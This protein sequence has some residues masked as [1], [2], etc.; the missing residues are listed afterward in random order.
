MHTSST[1]PFLAL[2]LICFSQI[3]SANVDKLRLIARDDPSTTIVIGW[4]QVTGATPIVYYD[5]IDHGTNHLAYAWAHNVDRTVSSKGMDNRFSRLSGLT[6]NKIYYFVIKDD[7]SVSARYSFKTAPNVP[8]ERL[9]IIAGGDSRS[10]Q[11]ARQN[12]NRLVGKLRAHAVLFGGDMTEFDTNAEW[13]TWF[14]DWQ[15]SIAADGR[16]TPIIPTRGNHEY[17]STVINELFDV[18]HVDAYYANTFGGTLYRAYTLNSQIATGGA[19][20][21]WLQGD[22]SANSAVTWKSAQYHT[23][24]RPHVASKPDR[25]DIYSDWL[26]SFESFGMSFVVE[27]DAHTVKTTHPI[28]SST[29]SSAVEGFLRD[30]VN[31]IVYVGE[32]CWGAPLR[33]NDDVKSWTRS[34]GVF[35]QFKLIFIE[36]NKIEIRTIR[37]DNAA[38]VGANT[39]ANIFALPSNL[40]VW[41]PA[42]GDVVVI[43]NFH[44]T[45]RPDISLVN[46]LNGQS[47]TNFNTIP[48]IALSTDTDGGTVDSVQFYVNGQYVGT[49]TSGSAAFRF[50]WTPTNSGVF[51]VYAKAFDN[52]M[53]MART[54]TVWITVYGTSTVVEST[55]WQSSDDAEEYT[56]GTVVTNSTTLDLTDDVSGGNLGQLIGLRFANL[57]IPQGATIHNAYIQFEATASNATASNLIVKIQDDANPLTFGGNLNISNR[58]TYV[59][60]IAWSPPAWTAGQQG[61]A[62]RSPD[63]TTLVQ[64]VV[65]KSAWAPGNPMAFVISGTGAKTAGSFDAGK[66]PRLVVEYSVGGNNFPGNLQVQVSSSDD[67]AEQSFFGNI[68]TTTSSDLDIV[69]EAGNQKIGIRFQN[70]TIPAGAIIESAF[71]QFVAVDVNSNATNFAIKIQDDV[72]PPAFEDFSSNGISN[73]PTMASTVSWSPVGWTI[74]GESDLKQRT[75]NLAP[76][77]QGMVNKAGWAAGNAM[78]FI[79]TGTGERDASAYDGDPAKAPILVVNYRLNIPPIVGTNLPDLLVCGT[80]PVNVNAGSGYSAYYWNNDVSVGQSST[81]AVTSGGTHTLRVMDAFGQVAYDTFEV[82]QGAAALPDLGANVV[83]SGTPVVLSPTGGPFASYLWNTGATTST[84]TVNA[85]GGYS[86]TV[87]NNDGCSGIDGV[88]VY[89]PS[90]IAQSANLKVDIYPNPTVDYINLKINKVLDANLS[91]KLI[92]ATGRVLVNKN[93]PNGQQQWM[94]ATEG[95]P[96]GLYWLLLTAD[97][98]NIHRQ[99]IVIQY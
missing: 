89:T 71:I 48:L 57:G 26:P 44:Q 50:D 33:A 21:T 92:D 12:A 86:V 11:A 32:G 98:K 68:V 77:L 56:G 70:V 43:E 81:F 25:N 10:N 53:K 55:I 1:L 94:V 36:L 80:A 42:E 38:S 2:L 62:Q 34:S 41:S 52:D 49:A 28:R 58:T 4:N 40:D 83:Y 30:D 16:I 95:I 31:G 64:W 45:G 97:N 93:L 29:A 17:S 5:T 63:L 61:V 74:V 76:L 9:S 73:R 78:A 8:T 96:Q 82:I 19:Q 14:D 67:D 79:I 54:S 75:T 90:A 84:I 87:T 37:V 39:D 23:P 18:N 27:C 13:Q 3:A 65:N 6:A 20:A 88:L 69:Y 47:F 24:I 85:V 35:N 72:N 60:S 59:N 51:S 22:L 66:A 15:L 7:N 91:L 46:P 99:A